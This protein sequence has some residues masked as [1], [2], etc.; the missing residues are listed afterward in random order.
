MDVLDPA[1][2]TQCLG[3]PA[4]SCEL[5]YHQPGGTVNRASEL[6]SAEGRTC[7][8]V[9]ALMIAD[10]PAIKK[11]TFEEKCP[12]GMSKIGLANDEGEDYHFY[13][14]DRDSFWSHKD[15]SNKAKRHDA[16]GRA[17]WDPK[18]AARDYRPNGSFL[19]YDKFCGYY[20]VPR[21]GHI[22]LARDGNRQS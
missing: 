7:K 4:G 21:N 14:Q 17:I 13:R 3:K 15:G 20:C 16:E 19:N 8:R 22:R 5:L 9:E 6:Y 12:P 18:T 1:Q 2:L 10:V 11:S